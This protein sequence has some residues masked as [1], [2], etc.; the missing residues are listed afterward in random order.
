MDILA[1][2][3]LGLAVLAVGV[4]IGMLIME[5]ANR[6]LISSYE[7]LVS[8]Q[9]RVMDLDNKIIDS[10]KKMLDL[11]GTMNELYEGLIQKAYQRLVELRDSGTEDLDEVIGELGEALSNH[12]ETSDS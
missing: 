8:S 4:Y 2:I 12:D 9:S 10:L 11:R 6:A 7:D 3:L 5:K 1:I